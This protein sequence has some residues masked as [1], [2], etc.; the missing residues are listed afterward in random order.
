MLG[1]IIGGAVAGGL[2]NMFS[3]AMDQVYRWNDN[4]WQSPLDA[5]KELK[6]MDYSNSLDILNRQMDY[7]KYMSS[8]AY[9]RAIEDLRAAGINPASMAGVNVQ[10]AASPLASSLHSSGAQTI[11]PQKYGNSM[12]GSALLNSAVNAAIAKDKGAA[13][14]MASE[15]I[16]NARHAHSI[17][18]HRE[19]IELS[20]IK[21]EA[22]QAQR[23]YYNNKFLNDEERRE[24]WRRKN[25]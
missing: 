5:T 23:N 25:D 3:G 18:E 17:E 1:S 10:A 24:A 4:N 13:Y 16:D 14:N 15:I 11:T 2:G 7:N 21:K 22:Y 9:Q 20:K 6:Q 8:T 12:F 19:D